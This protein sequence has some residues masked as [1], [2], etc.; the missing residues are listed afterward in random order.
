MVSIDQ[1]KIR[2]YH[3]DADDAH[4]ALMAG[5]D[6][7]RTA[8]AELAQAKERLAKAETTPQGTRRAI[9][10]TE[11]VEPKRGDYRSH[12]AF[13]AARD[14]YMTARNEFAVVAG[15]KVAEQRLAIAEAERERLALAWEHASRIR[16]LV[17]DY[18]RQHGQLPADLREGN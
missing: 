10:Q 8:R 12:E 16:S 15:V 7:V 13:A 14:E 3:S 5:W 4:A 6:R 1:N 2:K 18:A 11:P 17:T 9:Q